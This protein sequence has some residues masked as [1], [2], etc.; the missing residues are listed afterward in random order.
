MSATMLLE[1][2]VLL[3]APAARVFAANGSNEVLQTVR[4]A[5]RTFKGV[6]E[7]LDQTG[8]LIVTTD[9]GLTRRISAGE[10]F[11]GEDGARGE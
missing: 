7:G 9:E 6:F 8:A 1:F 4:L 5:A 10:V 11:F 2:D 3:D